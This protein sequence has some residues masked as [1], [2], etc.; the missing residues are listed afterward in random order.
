MEGRLFEDL[1]VSRGPGRRAGAGGMPVS[2]LLHAAGLTGLLSLSMIVP[3]DLP[4]PPGPIVRIPS[5]RAGAAGPPSST[6]PAPAPRRVSRPPRGS[7]VPLLVPTEETQAIEPSMPEIETDG[8][9]IGCSPV[10]EGPGG[11]GDE[12][13]VGDGPAGAPAAGGEPRPVRVG[14]N[15]DPPR[16]T[17]H[18]D[19]VYPELAKQARLAATVILECVIDRDGRV[20]RVTVLRGHPLFDAAAVEAVREWTYRP[21]RL[22]G[23]AVE[24]VMTVTVRFSPR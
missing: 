20:Q 15:I 14:G 7:V 16:K 3:D 22:N 24:V 12:D 2:M 6:P 18:V 8:G 10:G 1:V 5:A 19:P 21:T 11:P 17:R 13:A 4:A 23:I 9:C